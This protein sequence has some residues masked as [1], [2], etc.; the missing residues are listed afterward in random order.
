[1]AAADAVNRTLDD[2]DAL[3][4]LSAATAAEHL[5]DAK[6]LPALDRIARDERDGRI[7][8]HAAEA[9]IRVREA[10]TKPAELAR[11]RDEVDRLRTESRALRE[12]LDG[13]DP[14]G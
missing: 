9:A 10:Q 12:R 13:L 1:T 6:L 3:V 11:L 8:R 4:R 14:L 2:A 5:A 7:R